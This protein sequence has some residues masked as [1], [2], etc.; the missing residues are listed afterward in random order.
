MSVLLW[1]WNI[2][3]FGV[4]FLYIAKSCNF[5]CFFTPT[6]YVGFIKKVMKLLQTSPRYRQIKK[7]DVD[8][9]QL[10]ESEAVPPSPGKHLVSFVLVNYVQGYGALTPATRKSSCVNA[11]GIPTAAYQ[12][13]HLLSCTWGGTPRQE[14]TPIQS[15]TGG[16]PIQLWMGKVPHPWPGGYPPC[17]DLARVPPPSSRSGRGTPLSGPGWGTSQVWTDK[18]KI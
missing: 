2:Q 10:E 14:G 18:V 12:V 6:D 13:L 8:L 3:P 17:P 7:V 15:W 16:T 9:V 11:R 4:A 1:R 5:C